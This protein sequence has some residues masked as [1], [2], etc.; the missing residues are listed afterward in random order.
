MYEVIDRSPR[1]NRLDYFCLCNYK[2]KVIFSM[3]GR[4]GD[5]EAAPDN[6]V[7]SYNIT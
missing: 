6:S 4:V 3:G 5:R 2:D 7:E 1:V